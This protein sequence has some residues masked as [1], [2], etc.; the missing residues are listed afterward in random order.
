MFGPLADVLSE[1]MVK[2]GRGEGEAVVGVGESEGNRRE[3]IK[4]ERT[5]LRKNCSVELPLY[6]QY[7]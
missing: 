3:E 7:V 5:E 4:K 1:A 2:G 6:A